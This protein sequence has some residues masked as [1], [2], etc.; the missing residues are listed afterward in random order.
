MSCVHFVCLQVCQERLHLPP[1]LCVKFCTFSQ[2]R[3]SVFNSDDGRRRLR[4]VGIDT[5]ADVGE[6]LV[7]TFKKRFGLSALA[8]KLAKFV[9]SERHD[10]V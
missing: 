9:H 10:N 8:Q 2:D 3:D 1:S 5:P 4:N 7:D 6:W